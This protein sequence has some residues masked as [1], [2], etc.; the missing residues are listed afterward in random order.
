MRK[1]KFFSVFVLLSCLMLMLPSI[2]AAH[3]QEVVN[4]AG[5]IWAYKVTKAF[6]AGGSWHYGAY[7]QGKEGYWQHWQYGDWQT[8]PFSGGIANWDWWGT[9]YNVLLTPKTWL[10]VAWPDSYYG[11]NYRANFQVV[12]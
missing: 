6:Y 7:F 3:S 8:A 10:A 2:G 5:P 4:K 9:F 1:V 12:W 11:S